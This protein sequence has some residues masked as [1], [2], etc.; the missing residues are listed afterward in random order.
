[1]HAHPNNVHHL[2]SWVGTC[3]LS[4][5]KGTRTSTNHMLCDQPKSRYS[6][7]KVR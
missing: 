3:H 1:V 6:P 2:Y 5:D 7:I 4:A